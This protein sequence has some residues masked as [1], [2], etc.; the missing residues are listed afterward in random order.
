[1]MLSEYKKPGYEADKTQD[2]YILPKNYTRTKTMHDK[3][4]EKQ[5]SIV[6]KVDRSMFDQVGTK[7]PSINVIMSPEE[8]N[9]AE[10]NLINNTGN[11]V[12]IGKPPRVRSSYQTANIGSNSNAMY[13]HPRSSTK[14]VDANTDPWDMMQINNSSISGRRIDTA[15]SKDFRNNLNNVS[16][17]RSMS[18]DVEEYK[19]Y[20]NT[21]TFEDI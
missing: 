15:G 4:F 2:V 6:V 3:H 21:D 18:R 11:T 19:N 5:E 20:F 10:L 12:N 14:V 17:R 7:K 8:L 9:T 13:N 16:G 1:M